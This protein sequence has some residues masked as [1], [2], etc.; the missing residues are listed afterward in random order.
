[1][2]LFQT[3]HRLECCG[4]NGV[5]A[6]VFEPH[7]REETIPAILMDASRPGVGELFLHGIPRRRNSVQQDLRKRK[8][9]TVGVASPRLFIPPRCPVKPLR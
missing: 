7:L 2:G 4:I 3:R 1:M 8:D 6:N 5:K 9:G